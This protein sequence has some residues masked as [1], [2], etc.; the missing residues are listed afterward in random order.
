MSHGNRR[1]KHIVFIWRLW[2]TMHF[3]PGECT[4]MWLLKPLTTNKNWI[5]SP[6]E[7]ICIPLELL[8]ILKMNHWR[9]REHQ[10]EE[11]GYKISAIELNKGQRDLKSQLQFLLFLDL[12]VI[13]TV[14]NKL[15][16]WGGNLLHLR[17]N[18]FIESRSPCP[19]LI[20]HNTFKPVV[21]QG[22]QLRLM[23]HEA[24]QIDIHAG[25]I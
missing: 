6:V 4:W 8:A 15:R 19:S 14:K 17:T 7:E 1:I 16:K 3:I 18:K 24:K 23:G 11:N 10:D 12:N 13:G 9:N 25:R 5:L 22:T 2:Y 21:I 20:M